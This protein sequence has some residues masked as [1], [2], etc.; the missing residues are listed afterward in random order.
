MGVP[1]PGP[2]GLLRAVQTAAPVRGPPFRGLWKHT[3]LAGVANIVAIV[4]LPSGTWQPSS[5]LE[6]RGQK[7]S[8]NVLRDRNP[9]EGWGGLD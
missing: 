8:G 6:R 4:S 7:D 3:V 1:A 2:C 9:G 5:I